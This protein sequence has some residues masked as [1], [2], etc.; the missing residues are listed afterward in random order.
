MSNTDSKVTEIQKLLHLLQ[1]EGSIDYQFLEKLD[2]STFYK[3]HRSYIL[4]KTKISEK[5]AGSVII[6]SFKIPLSRNL[7]FDL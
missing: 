1:A 7:D 5:N 3:V 2:K 6:N 4:N